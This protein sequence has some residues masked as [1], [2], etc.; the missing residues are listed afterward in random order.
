MTSSAAA[1]TSLGSADL[2]MRR[3]TRAIMHRVLPDVRGIVDPGAARSVTHDVESSELHPAVVV[4]DDAREEPPPLVEPPA[5]VVEAGR[6]LSRS[7]LRANQRRDVLGGVERLRPARTASGRP[8]HREHHE[9]KP[10]QSHRLPEM[11]YR[12][13]AAGR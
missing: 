7:P 1:T 9:R 12:S 13:P 3:L 6:S 10:E 5:G 11:L 8:R 2:W 4:L